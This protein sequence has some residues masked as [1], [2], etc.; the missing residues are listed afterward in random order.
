MSISRVRTRVASSDWCASRNVVSVIS[1]FFCSSIHLTSPS[2]PRS[3]SICFTPGFTGEANLGTV[4]ASKSFLFLAS[5]SLTM[6]L[7]IYLSTFVALSCEL[8]IWNSSGD[9]SIKRVWH[10]PAWKVGWA[11][12]LLRNAVFV[13]T[14]RIRISLMARCILRTAPSKVRSSVVILTSRL[15]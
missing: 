4:G 5:G 10:R 7:P 1:S 8:C 9:S 15:S 2:G 6:M 12:M 14:P 11:I 13:F 3:S